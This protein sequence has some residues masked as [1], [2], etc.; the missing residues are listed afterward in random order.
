[1]VACLVA[2]RI[3]TDYRVLLLPPITVSCS[4]EYAGFAGTVSISAR[5]LMAVVE[6]TDP[7]KGDG[8][9]G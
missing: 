2:G 9:Y 1:M 6:D 5:T 4:H 7:F 3:A 8:E